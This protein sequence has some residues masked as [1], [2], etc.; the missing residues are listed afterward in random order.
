MTPKTTPSFILRRVGHHT[1]R[2]RRECLGCCGRILARV[3]RR[4]LVSSAIG[5]LIALVSLPSETETILGF[6]A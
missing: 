2:F 1:D 6:D 5:S 4:S 3:L